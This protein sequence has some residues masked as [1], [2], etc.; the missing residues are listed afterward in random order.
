MAE[1]PEKQD[2][3]AGRDSQPAGFADA[4]YIPR[5]QAP[6]LPRVYPVPAPQEEK[7]PSQGRVSAGVTRRV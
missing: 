7:E 5:D 6:N 4:S 2:T 3:A 1:R